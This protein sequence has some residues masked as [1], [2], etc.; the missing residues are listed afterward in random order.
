[1]TIFDSA[2]IYINQGINVRE[3]ITKIEAVITALEDSA[4]K[5]AANGS[6]SEYSLD[7][8]QTKIRTVYRN[9]TEVANAITA[10]ETIRQRWINQ[11]NGRQ[12]R[13]VDS[14][15]FINGNGR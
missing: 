11:L 15:N 3:K 7:D 13:L 12:V 2:D 8:G 10:F 5:A 6:V 14:K 9:A 4:L 1:M